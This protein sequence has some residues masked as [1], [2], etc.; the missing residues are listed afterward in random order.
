MPRSSSSSKS[1]QSRQSS[2]SRT[3]PPP[4]THTNVPGPAPAQQIQ[5]QTTQPS[6]KDTMFQGFAWGMGSSL[7]RRL[8]ETK[9]SPETTPYTNPTITPPNPVVLDSNEI[10][11]KYQECLERKETDVNCEMLLDMNSK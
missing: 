8:F 9:V 3:I 1:N 2:Q 6:F 11:K 5:V 10:F 4:K 7:G